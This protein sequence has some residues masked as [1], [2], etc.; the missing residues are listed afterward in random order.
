ML[1]QSGSV[2]SP[3]QSRE[4][5]PVPPLANPNGFTSAKHVAAP[6]WAICG[7]LVEVTDHWTDDVQ[8]RNTASSETDR[9]GPGM[10]CSPVAGAT[11][12]AFLFLYFLKRFYINIFSVSHFTVLYPYRPAGTYM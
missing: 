1:S 3:A 11:D 10:P 8:Q 4:V 12:A 9:T 7:H 6:A 2:F 5:E